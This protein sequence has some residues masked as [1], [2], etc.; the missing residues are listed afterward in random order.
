[1]FVGVLPS[2]LHIAFM[3]TV[4]KPYSVYLSLFLLGVSIHILRTLNIPG[5]GRD[6]ARIGES[7]GG[8]LYVVPLYPAL[9]LLISRFVGPVNL[10][11]TGAL[12][13]PYGVLTT[14]CLLL[15]KDVKM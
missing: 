3:A 9:F 8:V 14:Y 15:F 10:W 5:L 4:S 6:A 12:L 1:L 2:V 7:L 13:L 11:L